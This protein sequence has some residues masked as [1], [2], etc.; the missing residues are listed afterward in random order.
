VDFYDHDFNKNFLFS[1]GFH[2]LFFLLSFAGGQVVYRVFKANEVEIIQTS[3]RVDVVGMPKFT[4]DELKQ[5]EADKLLEKKPL[6]S[7]EITKIAAEETKVEAE[8]VIKKNDLVI[9]E[10]VK[11]KTSFLNL[12]QDYSSK[13]ISTSREKI[14]VKNNTSSNSLSSLVIEGNKISKGTALIGSYTDIQN[15]EFATYVQ[16]I[17]L[18]IK[19]YW[20]LPSYLMEKNLRCRIKI[21]LTQEGK[22]L[23]LE[24]QESSGVTEFDR[25]AES[26]I[27]ESSFPK[28]SAAVGPRLTNSG[29]ILG[30]PI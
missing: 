4:I 6:N 3:I 17:P 13:K 7:P 10:E 29:I 2:I 19:P 26:A 1:L 28:P 23:K 15:S 21:Y 27:R 12:L 18:A 9:Q 25:R 22:L 20:K 14:D 11:K 8:D 5:I 16:S 24:I 30:F